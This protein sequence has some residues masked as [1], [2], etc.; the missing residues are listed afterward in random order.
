M[1][2]KPAWKYAEE[3]V[4]EILIPYLNNGDLKDR[5]YS[6]KKRIASIALDRL[7]YTDCEKIGYIFED[8]ETDK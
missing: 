5:N 3:L 6:F 8:E 2:N 4:E 7:E 1:R